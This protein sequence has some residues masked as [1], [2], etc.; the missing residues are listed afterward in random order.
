MRTTPTG[1]VGS[2][3]HSFIDPRDGGVDWPE[4]QRLRDKLIALDGQRTDT[5]RALAAHRKGRRQAEQADRDAYAAALPDSKKDPGQKHVKQ[6]Q[7]RETELRRKA[8]ALESAV[9]DIDAEMD[10]LLTER[11][12]DYRATAEATRD[13]AAAAYAR[14]VSRRSARSAITLVCAYA[15]HNDQPPR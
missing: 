5:A 11:D 6:W 15:A 12:E 2:S 4:Y 13:E 14:G 1:R 7:E 8:E 3:S 9:A 10:D